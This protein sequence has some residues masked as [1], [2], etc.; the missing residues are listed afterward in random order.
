MN[1][2]CVLSL[3]NYIKL[4]YIIKF[5]NRYR[6][7]KYINNINNNSKYLTKINIKSIPCI[8]ILLFSIVCIKVTITFAMDKNSDMNDK[9]A[10]TPNI[11][12]FLKGL[13]PKKLHCYLDDEQTELDINVTAI[14]ESQKTKNPSQKSIIINCTIIHPQLRE[15][16]IF[17][18][19]TQVN[20]SELEL[21]KTL[22]QQPITI[23]QLAQLGLSGAEAVINYKRLHS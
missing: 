23:R 3:I 20:Q 11:S 14:K 21:L 15:P 17:G 16:L 7:V 10:S 5:L 22:V 2:T 1:N 13:V 12:N 6:L 18:S 19:Y 9:E 8:L 4:L